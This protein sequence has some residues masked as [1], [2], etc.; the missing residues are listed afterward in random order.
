MT[1][2]CSSLTF[3]TLYDPTNESPRCSS[4]PSCDAKRMNVS[5]RV[6]VCVGKPAPHVEIKLSVEE[7]SD[8][9]R[10]LMRGPHTM[11]HYWGQSP[12]LRSNPANEGWLD[13][14]DIGRIDDQGSLWL[15]G[16]E[17]DRIKS[18]GE[19]IYPEEVR[20]L[21]VSFLRLGFLLVLNVCFLR[22]N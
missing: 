22:E 19:N 9:G 3:M 11:L 6:G 13:T 2:A 16:R 21:Y 1:E 10:V 14:G 15:V 18:G 20:M 12:S 5:S 7:S 17:K 4:Q 8:A